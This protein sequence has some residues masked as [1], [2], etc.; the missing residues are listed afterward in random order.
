MGIKDLTRLLLFLVAL[1]LFASCD[2]GKIYPSE[3]AGIGEGFTVVMSGDIEG[4]ADYGGGYSL[5]L[6]VFAAGNEFAEVSKRV[7]P[8]AKNV[9]LRNV[10]VTDGSVEL[11]ILNSLRKRILTL[12][13][14]EI[15]GTLS[16]ESIRF[17]IG[18]VDV[19]AFGAIADR[20]FATTCLQCHGGTTHAAAGLD[21]NREKGYA[22]LVNM[23]S[24]VMEG[25][26]RV[27]PGNHRESTLW[28]AVATDDS[29]GWSFNHSNL[30]SGDQA[31]FIENW[32]DKG[33]EK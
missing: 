7:E 20:I 26:M 32:I 9:E 15:A 24:S 22:M 29:A 14:K 18:S 11:C 12:A 1:H 33:A 16:G 19:S 17:D 27:M 30:L 4:L 21:L 31:G 5:A 23:P 3:D 2:E 25:R 6:A 28:E 10:S 8:G 13:S